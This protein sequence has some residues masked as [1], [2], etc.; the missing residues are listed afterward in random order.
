M[1][2]DARDQRALQEIAERVQQG[3]LV[4]ARTRCETFLGSIGDAARQASVRTWLGMIER[5]SAN[6]P[7]AL[8]QFELVRQ[9]DRRNPHLLLQLGLTH[10]ELG[11]WERAEPLYREAIRLEPRL[12]LAHYN[13]GVLLQQKREF[14]AARRAFE[15]ALVHQPRFPEA[16]N[17][18]GNVLIACQ[19]LPGAEQCYRQALTLH[20]EFSYAH[21]GLGLLMMRQMRH[22]EALPSL[23]AAVRYDPAFL[24]GWLDL[25]ECQAQAGDVDAAKT[26]VAAVLARDPQHPVARFRRAMYAGEQPPEFTP[27]E[28]VERLYAGMAATFDEHL[29]K[30]LGYQTPALLAETVKPWLAK[31]EAAHARKPFVVDLGCGTGLFGMQ[32]RSVCERLV[33][34]DLSGAMLETARSR[35]VYDEL[36]TCDVVAYLNANQEAI[37]LIAASDVLI[38]IGNLLPMFA[39]VTARLTAGG[40]FVFSTETPDELAEG[41]CLQP[42]GR[43]AHSV[44]YIEQQAAE[45]GLRVIGSESTVI[46]TENAAAVKGFL[47]VIEKPDLNVA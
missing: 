38:Y 29:L 13:L 24:D 5:R 37:D 28:L 33:G 42:N 44:R 21:H 46:R 11:Q 18:L 45:N 36:V 4:G 22:A 9:S 31:F 43:Y 16:L 25:A 12:P 10:F 27:P 47:F 14:P 30:H 2:A 17:N 40:A 1:L 20:A 35:G 7:A 19:D 34:V 23:H 8:A 41:L 26:S 6:L 3:D 32:I 39:A 15:A